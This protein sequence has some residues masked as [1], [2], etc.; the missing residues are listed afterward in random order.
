MLIDEKEET[1]ESV[2]KPHESEIKLF[3]VF[4]GSLVSL[5]MNVSKFWDELDEIKINL[6]LLKNQS[7]S[8]NLNSRGF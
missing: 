4:E 1:N 7:K 2:K 3:K 8:F 5:E 6:F